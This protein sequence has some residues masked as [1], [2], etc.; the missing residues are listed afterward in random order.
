MNELIFV[1]S[2]ASLVTAL[3]KRD[4][5]INYL[6]YNF[7]I[8]IGSEVLVSILAFFF[9]IVIIAGMLL[10][11]TKEKYNKISQEY[12]NLKPKSDDRP[13]RY[14]DVNTYD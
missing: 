5:I 7:N 4:K 10:D 1:I 13:H 6:S 11:D 12:D 3:I 2:S 9:I 8:R 14:F